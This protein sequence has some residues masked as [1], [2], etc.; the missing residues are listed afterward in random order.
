MTF[1]NQEVKKWLADHGL[2]YDAE[3]WGPRSET[4]ES[5]G[6]QTSDAERVGRTRINPYNPQ[7]QGMLFFAPVWGEQRGVEDGAYLRALEE[8]FAPYIAMVSRPKGALLKQLMYEQK[9]YAEIGDDA[10]MT[11]Q[12]AYA[13][14]SRA[15]QDLTKHIAQDDP[16]FVPPADGRRRDHAAEAEAARRVFERYMNNLR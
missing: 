16:D 15:V 2:P 7:K 12:G 1:D 3:D 10:G 9:T 6:K 11:R 13:A 14:I 8:F 4:G 5:I